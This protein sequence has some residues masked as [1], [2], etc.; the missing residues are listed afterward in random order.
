ML[1]LNHTNSDRKF[2]DTQ[3]T[4]ELLNIQAVYIAKLIRA[5]KLE[6]NKV[7]SQ[8]WVTRESIEKYLEGAK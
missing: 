2:F 7:G 1:N 5:G 3:E 8:W 4:A 6:G